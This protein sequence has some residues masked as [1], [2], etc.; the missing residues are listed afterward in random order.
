M[1]L[2]DDNTALLHRLIGVPPSTWGCGADSGPARTSPAWSNTATAQYRAIRYTERFAEA[3][4]VASVGSR[5]D[6]YN[7][8]MAEARNSL[9]KGRVHPQ[10]RDA[11]QGR[12]EER[13]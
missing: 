1:G 11:T 2:P 13:R 8:A 3:V 6:S 10:P 9:F 12:L 7:I 5:G 4:A